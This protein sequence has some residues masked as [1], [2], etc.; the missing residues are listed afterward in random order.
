[1]RVVGLGPTAGVLAIALTYAGMLG[2]VYGEILE[3]TDRAPTDALLRNGAS[4][5]GALL[6]GTLPQSAPELVSYPVFRW[7]C[8]VRA[9]VIMGFVGA[10]GLGQQM[11]MSMKM[12]AGDEVATMLLVFMLLVA[13]ADRA[14]RFLR[15]TLDPA[16]ERVPGRRRGITATGTA[17]VLIAASM[18][19]L[20]LQWLDFVAPDAIA[21]MG[22]FIWGFVPPD[23]SADFMARIGIGALETLS[24]SA[25]G[26]L[27]AA[28]LGVL[29]A[30]PAALPASGIA[31]VVLRNTTR[32]LLNAL[33]SIPELVWAALWVIAAGLGP[34][35]GTLA[36]AAHT[37]GVIGRLF[38]ETL[39][40]LPAAPARALRDN[41]VG[42]AA[43]FLYAT[44]PQSL[45]QLMSYTL[46]R[47]EN[48]IRAAA[49]LG[50]V[51]AGG[52]G[53]L[54]HYHLSLFQMAQAASV[55][56]AM[57]LIVTAVDGVSHVVRQRLTA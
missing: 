45:P 15:D 52:L 34:L 10:G 23:V 53:Q 13:M 16:V 7:E 20:D 17:L 8:A 37:V 39:E 57:V 1:V 5:T 14:S 50:V 51:G 43:T 31:N 19:T 6:Y 12:L 24:M 49:V 55:I 28:L 56:L 33:R 42:Y 27:L 41:G 54:L 46:Y 35:A 11:E 38:A 2:K 29:L 9:S 18:A 44:L 25:I 47:W 32:G 4:R 48:N 21:R 3:S 22:E 36:L 30:I 26:T 40:N